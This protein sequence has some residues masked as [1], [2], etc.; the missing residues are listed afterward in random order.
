MSVAF[1]HISSRMESSQ[2]NT[3][4]WI[5]HV[6]A[7]LNLT[8][9]DLARRAELSPSTLTRYLNDNSGQIGISQRSLDKIGE[10]ARIRPH[11]FQTSPFGSFQEAEATPYDPGDA[12]ADWIEKQVRDMC[13]AVQSRVPWTLRT[14]AL[15]L[16][17]YL[18]G[19]IVIVDLSMPAR[20]GDIVCAQL[21]DWQRET[22][23]T[24]FRLYRKPWLM[25]HSSIIAPIQPRL[26]DD[27]NVAIKGVV[28][29]VLRTRTRH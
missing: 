11:Q 8:P 3:K 16:L 25:T 12:Q 18:K 1:A 7:H 4:D 21:Y 28:E 22:A 9:S 20:D 27:D 29:A 15:N 2:R 24:V 13:S 14:D 26:V 6:A 5:K 23:D 19:D 10:Y 17:G